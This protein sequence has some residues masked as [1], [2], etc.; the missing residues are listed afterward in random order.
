M[1]GGGTFGIGSMRIGAARLLRAASASTLRI[2]S[3]NARRSRVT[4]DSFSAGSTLRNW[5]TSA[6]R[7]RS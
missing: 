5:A 2:A 1:S 4:S 6:V 7:A 3:S